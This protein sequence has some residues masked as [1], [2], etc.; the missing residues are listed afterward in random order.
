MPVERSASCVAARPPWSSVIRG[1]LSMTA[2]VFAL[3]GCRASLPV[4]HTAI[5]G[6]D[7]VR[8]E[9]V[10]RGIVRET[11]WLAEGPWVAQ[12][13]RVD[14]ARCRCQLDGLHAFD[15]IRGR[16]TVSAMVN[17]VRARGVPVLA[18]IN[19]DFFDLKTGDV[20]NNQVIGG[21]WMKG[22]V[23]SESPHHTFPTVHGQVGQLTDGRVVIGRYRMRGVVRFERRE[24]GRVTSDSVAL[25]AINP[26]RRGVLR[27][28]AYSWRHGVRTPTSGMRADSGETPVDPDGVP[29]SAARLAVAASGDSARMAADTVVREVVEIAFRPIPGRPGRF[30]VVDGVV[31]GRG[32]T[33]IPYDGFVLSLWRDESGLKRLL[34][35][36]G[37]NE[38]QLEVGA[39]GERGERLRGVRTLVGG[40]GELVVDSTDRSAR[41]DSLEGTFPRFSA[42][43]HPR[44]AVGLARAG[45]EL[46]LVGVD[47]R[48]S[49]GSTG[50]SLV[51]LGR[52]MRALGAT[53][54]ANLDGGGST[55][56]W[57]RGA[58]V[59]NRP[60][61][62]TG[63]RPVGNALIVVGR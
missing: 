3:S 6:R 5:R 13:V 38:M 14:L 27:S 28:V 31:T 51:E 45:R 24:D 4:A 46:L 11:H 2:F 15:G 48:G 42:G 9:S 61:D 57:V 25:D 44:T 21:E 34:G 41:V 30:R 18:A 39:V 16:E 23:L 37:G 43:R 32:G 17:R 33:K 59:V 10:S 8:V 35:V 54:A 62:P 20:E 29:A 50:M 53:A 60:S 22:T 49:N 19:A 40:W 56:V 12:V 26:Q 36:T 63:E 52:W 1:A 58:G 7:S 55:T 47:G